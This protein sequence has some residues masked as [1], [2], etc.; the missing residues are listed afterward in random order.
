MAAGCAVVASDLASF[1][2]VLGD[3]GIMVPV[4]DVSALSESVSHL[5]ADDAELRRYSDAGGETVQR[6]D[7]SVVIG[8]YQ[9]AYEVAMS[10]G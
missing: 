8:E 9:K 6:Y 4:A 1:R 10:T 3:S 7:W 2:S 5:L